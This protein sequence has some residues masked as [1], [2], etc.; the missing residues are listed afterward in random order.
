[1][2]SAIKNIIKVIVYIII[3][4]FLFKYFL[5]IFAPF[6]NLFLI[7][8][9]GQFSRYKNKTIDV[10]YLGPSG[11]YSG[12][13]PISI[14]KNYGITGFDVSIES[15]VL[16]LNNFQM[17]NL[18]INKKQDAKVLMLDLDTYFRNFLKSSN[19]NEVIHKNI[20][21]Y[22]LNKSKID[23][24]NESKYGFNMADKVSYLIP[25]FSYHDMW[26]KSVNRYFDFDRLKSSETFKDGLVCAGARE[27][28]DIKKVKNQ[29]YMQIPTN[30]KDENYENYN[31]DDFLRIKKYCEDNNI[32]LILIVAPD[33]SAWDKNKHDTI[34]KL[35]SDNNLEYLDFNTMYDETKIDMNTDFFDGAA[36]L[37]INGQIKLSN[38]IGQYL[39][40]NYNLEDHRGDPKYKQWDKDLEEYKKY[41]KVWLAE[42]NKNLE[43]LQKQQEKSK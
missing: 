9:R 35:A 11:T 27:S 16:G 2:K 3:I 41:E 7:K 36:H 18:K 42:Y 23:F 17:N 31:Y 26:N 25:F 14:Y 38:Y 28:S 15:S 29:Y 5:N 24:V 20:D 39:K 8:N 19:K 22:R 4:L 37:N 43:N 12:I 34:E 30:T 6:D 13:S 10:I 1:M 32:K 21:F 40:D 33:P